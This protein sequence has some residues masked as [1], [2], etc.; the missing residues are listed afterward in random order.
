MLNSSSTSSDPAV[1]V[2]GISSYVGTIDNIPRISGGETSAM[3]IGTTMDNLV[4]VSAL[5]GS[6][7]QTSL[8]A[9][10]KATNKATDDKHRIV[11]S[12]CL[13]RRANHE[14]DDSD[15]NRV[16]TRVLFGDPALVECTCSGVS[17]TRPTWTCKILPMNAPSSIMAVMSPFQKALL[18]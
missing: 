4:A 2:R 9:D 11:L 7:T 10:T 5:L 14:D 8:H 6:C 3:Y 12:A 13:N 18:G 16:T 17:Y 15:N 1:G